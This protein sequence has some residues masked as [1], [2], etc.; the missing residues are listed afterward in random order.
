[1]AC[2]TNPEP[3]VHPPHTPAPGACSCHTP[4]GRPRPRTP[5]GAPAPHPPRPGRGSSG[6]RGAPRAARPLR[7]PALQGPPPL[8]PWGRKGRGRGVVRDQQRGRDATQGPCHVNVTFVRWR[9]SVGHV[10]SC[11]TQWCLRRAGVCTHTG[12]VILL[13]DL[14]QVGGP[15]AGGCAHIDGGGDGGRRAPQPEHI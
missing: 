8:P 14:G 1:M 6:A 12:E 3:S 11:P 4:A 9:V 15:A 2:K 13:C 10:G 5:P 7:A